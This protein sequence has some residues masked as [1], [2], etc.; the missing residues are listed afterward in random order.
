M[1]VKGYIT[2]RFGALFWRRNITKDAKALV[3][4]LAVYGGFPKDEARKQ[5]LLDIVIDKRPTQTAIETLKAIRD[6]A[7]ENEPLMTKLINEIG[8]DQAGF[9][10]AVRRYINPLI[11]GA[12]TRIEA[13]EKI[14]REVHRYENSINAL[15][16][17]RKKCM[18]TIDGLTGAQRL[19]TFIWMEGP[20]KAIAR[21]DESYTKIAEAWGSINDRLKAKRV[22]KLVLLT[23]SPR[24]RREVRAEMLKKPENFP[25]SNPVDQ[26]LAQTIDLNALLQEV[27]SE[28]PL[29]Q[30]ERDN[31]LQKTPSLKDAYDLHAGIYDESLEKFEKTRGTVEKLDRKQRREFKRHIEAEKLRTLL[32]F[33]PESKESLAHMARFLEANQ[34][35]ITPSNDDLN[36]ALKWA[37]HAQKE[38]ITQITALR[39]VS[40]ELEKEARAANDTN[41]GL[42]SLALVFERQA[43]KLDH[44]TGLLEGTLRKAGYY[45]NKR[46][47]SPAFRPK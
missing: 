14:V 36:Y 23:Y 19:K 29:I 15:L 31:A 11:A 27:K 40:L 45:L 5:Q 42:E 12:P 44:K 46:T 35:P 22:S 39:A 34:D 28:I 3:E 6:V 8:I 13:M 41:A 32:A 21:A 26:N 20:A 24:S 25:A 10:Q 43:A 9:H 1:V 2:G 4:E 18:P 17:D 30:N 33:A 7:L 16:K 47:D 37:T 38:Q